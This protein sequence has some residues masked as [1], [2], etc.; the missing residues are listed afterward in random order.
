[1]ESLLEGADPGNPRQ[2]DSRGPGEGSL[3]SKPEGSTGPVGGNG[4]GCC[5]RWGGR[6]G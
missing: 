1:M 5:P 3:S 2:L 4:P 6:A